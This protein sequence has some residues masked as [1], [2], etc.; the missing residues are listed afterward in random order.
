MKPKT[1]YKALRSTHWV[2]PEVDASRKA[3]EY[4]FAACGKPLQHSA[5]EYAVYRHWA[6]DCPDC[7]Q[8]PEF[9]KYLLQETLQR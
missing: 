7:R 1:Q 6:V 2:S 8:D 9:K 3:G 4:F 5:Y